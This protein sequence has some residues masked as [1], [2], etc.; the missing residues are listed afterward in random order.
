MNNLMN[1]SL[2]QIVTADHKAAAVFEKHHLDFC[3][4]GKRTLQQACAEKNLAIDQ[5]LSELNITGNP[6]KENNVAFDKLPLSE[7]SEYIVS[8]HHNYVKNELPAIFGYLQ[9]VASKHGDRHPELFKVFEI[10]A[11]VKEEMEMHM[12]KEEKILFPRISEIEKLAKENTAIHINNGFLTAPINMME[13]EHDHAGGLLA[14]ISRLTDNYTP[15]AD[16][17]TTYKLS[18]ASLKA[19]ETDLHLHIH[20]ENNVLFPKALELFETRCHTSLN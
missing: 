16:A 19:F 15:P 17:C 20:L 10:F 4:K 12:Q 1:K 6:E 2:A 5:I 11:A 8:T 14:E 9:K 3:C 13:Q 7:L 18:Y